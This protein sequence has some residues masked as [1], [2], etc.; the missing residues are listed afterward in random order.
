MP[1]LGDVLRRFRFHG[2]P[3]APTV[4]AVPADRTAELESELA[5]VFAALEDAQRAAAD[6]VTAAEHRARE[7]RAVA[8]TEGERIVAAAR[9]GVTAARDEAASARLTSAESEAR[10]VIEAG[11]TEAARVVRVAA[12]RAD[13]VAELVVTRILAAATGIGTQEPEP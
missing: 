13:A 5:P 6:A 11:R 4:V 2:V 1:A 10:Q 9:A 8:I 3:G 12:Q 7:R